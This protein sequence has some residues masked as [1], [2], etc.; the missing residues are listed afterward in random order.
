MGEQESRRNVIAHT[1]VADTD[2]AQLY[3][4]LPDRIR[5]EDMITEQPAHDPGDPTLGGRDPERD[6]MLRYA[7]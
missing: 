5:P 3:A 1:D 7:G 4:K 2:T 6:W